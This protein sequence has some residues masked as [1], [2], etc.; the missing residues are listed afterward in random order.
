MDGVRCPDEPTAALPLL[1]WW[2][3]LD[4]DSRVLWFWHQRR[5]AEEAMRV[6]GDAALPGVGGVDVLDDDHILGTTAVVAHGKW[7]PHG[8]GVRQRQTDCDG[9]HDV[10]GRA[11]VIVS[12]IVPVHET[13]MEM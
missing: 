3:A 11:G 7:S 5:S 6:R 13:Q 1:L 12:R 9:Q 8:L 2:A 4:G 10:T